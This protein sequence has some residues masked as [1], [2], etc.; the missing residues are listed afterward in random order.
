MANS[1]I[2]NIQP[3]GDNWEWQGKTFYDFEITMADGTTGIASSTNPQEPSYKVGD[4]VNYTAKETQ[5]GIKLKIKKAGYMTSYD[6]NWAMQ[7]A[8]MVVGNWNREQMLGDY[9]NTVDEVAKALIQKR[10]AS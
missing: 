1:K 9:L 2:H 5:H 3:T 4:E 8:V 6:K 10:D 7:T